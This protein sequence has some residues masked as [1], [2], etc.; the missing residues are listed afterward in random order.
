[1]DLAGQSKERS[2]AT[3]IDLNSFSTTY[4]SLLV[5]RA[6]DASANDGS[7]EFLNVLLQDASNN[8]A[9]AFGVGSA[10]NIFVNNLGGVVTTA[11]DEFDL[12]ANYFLLAKI[13]SRPSGFDQIFFKAFKSGEDM[14]PKNE[15]QF[16]WTVVGMANTDSS[17]LISQIDISG[18]ANAIW[19]ID[20]VRIGNTYDSV[21]W[22]NYSTRIGSSNL[23]FQ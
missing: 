15:Y 10:E 17:A 12:G 6:L 1:M 20:E 11:N 4:V 22:S 23:E 8:T 5:S 13:V 16:G 3:S 18:G 19:S 7:G 2:L 21:A 14:I 9:A